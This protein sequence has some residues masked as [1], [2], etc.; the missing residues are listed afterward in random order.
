MN[1]DMQFLGLDDLI[2]K[3]ETMASSSELEEVNKKIVEAG[4]NFAN[5][6]FKAEFPKSSDNGKS[7]IRGKHPNGHFADNVPKTSI[8][9]KGDYY[10]CTLGEKSESGLYAYARFR[11]WGTSKIQASHTFEKV[12]Q[13]TEEKLLEVGLKEYEKLLKEKIGG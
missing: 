3:V 7:G 10:Y 6:K 1:I 12:K 13:A 8:K 2:K 5:D 11:D 9:R 4:V